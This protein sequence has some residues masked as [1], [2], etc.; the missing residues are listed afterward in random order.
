MKVIT[1][2]GKKDLA[3]SSA[4]VSLW[5]EFLWRISHHQT[6]PTVLVIDVCIHWTYET[7]SS[8]SNVVQVFA[9]WNKSLWLCLQIAN[10]GGEGV[11][12]ANLAWSLSTVCVMMMMAQRLIAILTNSHH[13]G[14]LSA[15][16]MVGICHWLNSTIDDDDLKILDQTSATKSWDKKL[17]E[18]NSST[19]ILQ[20]GYCCAFHLFWLI[21]LYF[22]H[23]G[24]LPMCF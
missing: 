13:G 4:P 15:M 12:I 10:V 23:F 11:E 16:L 6:P 20:S 19:Y 5:G 21:W 7:D 17:N 14:N 1:T 9:T 3:E 18:I 24:Y 8:F 22:V 2:F